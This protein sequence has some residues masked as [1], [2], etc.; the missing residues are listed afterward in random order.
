M[1]ALGEEQFE[2]VAAIL[3]KAFGVGEDVHAFK[4]GSDAGREQLAGAGDFDQA[5]A[6]CADIAE[7]IE[8][9]EGGDVDVVLTGDFE[10]GLTPAAAD[11]MAVDGKSF[12]VD[13]VGHAITS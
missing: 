12:D 1:I 7:A 6:A 2:D 8:M 4:D 3:L 5:D 13:G 9:A 11:L 10:D